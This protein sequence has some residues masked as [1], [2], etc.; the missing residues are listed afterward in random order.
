MAHLPFSP[1]KRRTRQH[2]IAAQSVNYV[3]RF[4]VDEG[5]VAQRQE[6]DYGYD[7]F[8]ITYDERGYVEPGGV[9]LQLKA[10]EN[11][12][13]SGTDWCYD[14]DVRDYNLW[15]AELMPVLLILFDA[16]RRKAYWLDFQHYF[17]EFPNRRPKWGAK[18][19]RVRIPD[20]QSLN[21]RSI[22]RMRADKE[23]YMIQLKGGA[24]HD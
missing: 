2:V 24:R 6:S 7:L 18:T 13:R 8:L 5:H 16:S 9:Y 22:R 21:H 10:S 1:R 3:E 15:M 14:V 11:L 12:A 19:V 4:I 20:R 17:V 23:N